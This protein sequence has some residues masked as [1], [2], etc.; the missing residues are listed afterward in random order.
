MQQIPLEV[1][2]ADY[3]LFDTFYTGPNGAAVLALQDVARDSSHALL[4]ICGPQDAG[5]T[6]LLQAC[7][8]AADTN[9]FRTAYLPLGSDAALP[10]AALDGMGELDVIC[11]DDVGRV[12][13]RA[14]WERALFVLYEGIR[15]RGGRLILAAD[16]APVQGGFSLPDL[17]SRFT[18][19]ATFRLQPLTDDDRFK[20]MQLRAKWR[21]LLLPDDTVRYLISRVDRRSSTLFSLL[22][23]LDREALTAQKRLTVPFVKS[24]LDADEHS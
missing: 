3:A 7:V 24:V 17:V 9:G 15:Q 6:H 11:I 1:R 18:S 23:R 22:D 2:L 13:G 12:A 16:T 4:W 21:G 10:V 8:N 14:E 5:K 20:A 19:G